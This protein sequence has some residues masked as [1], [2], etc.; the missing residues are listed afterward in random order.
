M[1]FF[2]PPSTQVLVTV[3]VAKRKMF[4]F[5]T[6]MRICLPNVLKTTTEFLGCIYTV[7]V[8]PPKLQ[9]L[10]TAWTGS[11]YNGWLQA[12]SCGGH[13]DAWLWATSCGG[14]SDALLWAAR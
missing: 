3:A 1:W 10:L 7:M 13:F 5:L 12:A 4:L 8:A 2:I 9:G 11:H 6:Q 14:Y